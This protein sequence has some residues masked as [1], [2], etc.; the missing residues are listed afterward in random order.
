ME[1]HLPAIHS[2]LCNINLLQHA[3]FLHQKNAYDVPNLSQNRFD[4]LIN[5]FLKEIYANW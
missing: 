4:W 1:Y 5:S 2:N 3:H